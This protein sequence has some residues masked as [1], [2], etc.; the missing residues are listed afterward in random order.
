MSE[1]LFGWNFERCYRATLRVQRSG[2]TADYAVLAAGIS[3][4]QHDQEALATCGIKEFLQF[5]YLSEDSCSLLFTL[6]SLQSAIIVRIKC[7]EFDAVCRFDFM[8]VTHGRFTY[9]TN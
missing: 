7:S 6:F 4:L 9:A 3:P 1:L 5:D 2:D 8:G